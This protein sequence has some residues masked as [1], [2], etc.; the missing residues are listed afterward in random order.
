MIKHRKL[1]KKAL[2][3]VLAAVVLT[4]SSVTA[5]AYTDSG[6]GETA[7]E[8]EENSDVVGQEDAAIEE[9][10]QS[11]AAFSTPGNGQVQD[12]ITDDSTKEFLTI[13]TKNNNTFYLVID[14]STS[15]ENVYML[16]QIDENDLQEFLEEGTVTEITTETAVVLEE[17]D[18]TSTEM[19]QETD[20]AQEE[21]QKEDPDGNTSGILI[22]L[23]LA[24]AG[25][26]AY[27]FFRFHRKKAEVEEEHSE[28]IE[29]SDGLETVDEREEDEDYE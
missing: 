27:Y 11:G 21:N 13:T 5:F 14:R 9:T 3:A 10:G 26:G 8:A 12:D 28:G 6:T 22:I 2:A 19:E 16:S 17:N 1:S 25:I 23:L 15:S 29:F 4:G 24:G 18:T 7:Q 20:P